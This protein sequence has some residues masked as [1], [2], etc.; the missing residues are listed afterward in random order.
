M[1]IGGFRR[2]GAVQITNADVVRVNLALM[3]ALGSRV[4]RWTRGPAATPQQPQRAQSEH[5]AQ[6][7]SASSARSEVTPASWAETYWGTTAAVRCAWKESIQEHAREFCDAKSVATANRTRSPRVA[8]SFSKSVFRVP[9]AGMRVDYAW[10]AELSRAVVSRRLLFDGTA[11]DRQPGDRVANLCG[12][13]ASCCE[14]LH[15]LIPALRR[16]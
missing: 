6:Q 8:R 7:S 4:A 16:P 1:R 2:V 10:V 13:P 9:W 11:M 14:T 12:F 3:A 5:N 15:S